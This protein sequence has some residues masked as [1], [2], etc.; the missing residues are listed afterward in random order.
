MASPA[1][2]PSFNMNMYEFITVMNLPMSQRCNTLQHW[3]ENGS[4]MNLWELFPMLV[5]SIFDLQGPGW[6]LRNITN[7]NSPYDYELLL[8]FFSPLRGPMIRLCYRLMELQPYEVPLGCLPPKMQYMLLSGNYTPFYSKRIM[9]DAFSRRVAGLMLNSFEYFILYFGLYGSVPLRNLYPNFMPIICQPTRK[10]TIYLTIAAD[11]FVALVPS[12]SDVY[13]LAPNVTPRRP[14]PG[15][16]QKKSPEKKLSTLKY[17]LP[18]RLKVCTPVPQPNPADVLA[19][20]FHWRTEAVIN[21]LASSWF[22]MDVEESSSLPDSDLVRYVRILVKQ[23]HA[24]NNYLDTSKSAQMGVLRRD[25]EKAL[26]PQVTLFLRALFM[27]WPLNESF[28]DVLELWLS[29]IQPWRYVDGQPYRAPSDRTIETRYERFIAANLN[30]YSEMFGW[31]MTRLAESTDPIDSCVGMLGRVLKVFGQGNLLELLRTQE[32]LQR[33]KKQDDKALVHIVSPGSKTTAMLIRHPF[34][35]PRPGLLRHEGLLVPMFSSETIDWALE[36]LMNKLC[37]RIVVNRRVLQDMKPSSRS[38]WLQMVSLILFSS[39]Q[40]QSDK[41]TEL[42]QRLEYAVTMLEQ[43]YGQK[44]LYETGEDG[45]ID[46]D[47]TNHFPPPTF[48]FIHPA[49]QPLTQSENWLLARLL[50][51]VCRL[52]NGLFATY[53]QLYWDSQGLTGRIARCLLEPPVMFC[54]WVRQPNGKKSFMIRQLPARVELRTFGS[55]A[56]I[57]VMSI[58]VLLGNF[59]FGAPSYGLFI[60]LLVALLFRLVSRWGTPPNQTVA[61]SHQTSN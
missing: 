35:D 36:K 21:L 10:E 45:S 54:E 19:E 38:S 50:M 33:P 9:I 48:T 12:S 60:L 31:F 29:Y 56:A 30:V 23:V 49:Y 25:V 32:Y 53:F 52:L 47:T 51:Q 55:Y 17:L 6:N 1:Q 7:E 28:A 26:V 44:A 42:Q 13:L 3:F 20:A 18:Q 2:N 11:L 40:N 22:G 27:F 16:K 61:N 5:N 46:N 58:S 43:D 59:L 8:D 15:Q 37:T 39:T 41:L 34:D 24:F 14:A 57:I 4:V